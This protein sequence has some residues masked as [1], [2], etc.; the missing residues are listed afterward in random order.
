[1]TRSIEVPWVV[2]CCL[3][4]LGIICIAA[5]AAPWL[6]PHDPDA[7]RIL[8]KLRPP[9]GLDGAEP[10]HWLGTDPLGRDLMSRCLHGIRISVG[11]AL[12]G[13]IISTTIGTLAGLT[14]GMLGGMSDRLIMMVADVFI[15]VPHLLLVLVGIAVFG[16]DIAVL[17][18]LLGLARWESCARIVRG[19]VL[20]VREMPYVLAAR[21]MG[22]STSWIARRH[23]LPNIASPLI[24]LMTLNFPAI[25]LM[26]SSLSFLG[27]GVQPPTAS[28]GRMVGDGRDHLMLAWWV[29]LAPAA[30]VVLITLI[31][32]VLGDWLRDVLD[33]RIKD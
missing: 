17:V 9:I 32:Q 24:V 22:A 1:M 6:A 30:V 23:I 14:A 10:D 11:M 4:I 26:E 31:V 33:V 25:L 8:Y 28:L 27:I 15:T 13:L 19:Q 29:A 5:I 18:V 12:L 20:Q 2:R 16:T 3:C 7:T 21:S